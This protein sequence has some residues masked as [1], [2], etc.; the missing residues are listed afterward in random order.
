MKKALPII[1][2]IIVAILVS[3]VIKHFLFPEDSSI[4][5]TVY[6]RVTGKDIQPEW[7]SRDFAV[8]DGDIEG[9]S[10]SV[11]NALENAPAKSQAEYYE[12]MDFIAYA[13]IRYRNEHE[14]A[15]VDLSSLDESEMMSAAL[16]LMYQLGLQDGR[17]S[18]ARLLAMKNAVVKNTPAY[19]EAFKDEYFRRNERELGW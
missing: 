12:Y 1:L 10:M 6:T 13:D 19:Y 16:G 7:M 11:L 4:T 14:N 17:F 18:L 15:G 5:K 2:A 3:D 9:F 8:F